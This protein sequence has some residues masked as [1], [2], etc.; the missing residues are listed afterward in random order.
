LN[1]LMTHPGSVWHAEF[2]ADGKLILTGDDAG[3]ARLWDGTT[4]LPLAGWAR[5][6]VSLKRTHL[7]PDGKWALSAAEDGRVRVWPVLYAS[8]PAPTWLP[9][10]AEALAGRRLRDDGALEQVPPEGWFALNEW[11]AASTADDLYSRWAKW[12]LVERMKEKP[13]IFVP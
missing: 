11:L 3:N 13:L 6:G 9:K 10:V 4:G 2:S 12:F 8:L 5:N 7:S 1:E